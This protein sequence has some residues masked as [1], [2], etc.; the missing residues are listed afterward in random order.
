MPPTASSRYLFCTAQNDAEGRLYLTRRIPYRY[1]DLVDNRHHV[2]RQGDTLWQIAHRYFS[3]TPNAAWLW[4]VIAEFQPSPILDPTLELELGRTL[5][6]PATR[7]LTDAIFNPA[8][9]E[10]TVL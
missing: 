8:R 2:C 4:W 3:P 6:I 7:L 10:D 5:V 9:A 1:R